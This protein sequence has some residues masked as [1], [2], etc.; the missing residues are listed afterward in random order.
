MAKREQTAAQV[1]RRPSA[2]TPPTRSVGGPPAL[3]A[4]VRTAVLLLVA[5]CVVGVG[6]LLV[7]NG[8]FGVLGVNVQPLPGLP[9]LA[10][11][12]TEAADLALPRRAWTAA[13]VTVMTKPGGSARL[14]TLEPGFP[15]TITAHQ[16][17]GATVWSHITWDGPTSA[18]GGEGW[19][20]DSAFVSY[21]G[22]GRQ[23]GD[24]GALSPQL[25]AATAPYE[26]QFSAALYFPEV[27]QLYRSRGDQSFALGDGF[28]SVL[29]AAVFAWNE[30]QIQ[31]TGAAVTAATAAGVARGDAST[32]SFA[33]GAV[34]DKAGTSA[35]LTKQEI[36]GIQP[37]QGNWQGAQ[38]TPN[39]LLQFYA[40]L[41]TKQ[42]LNDA[43]RATVTALLGHATSPLSA[44]LMTILSPGNG[45]FLV[46]GVSQGASGW[47]VSVCGMLVPA[48]GSRVVLAAVMRDQATQSAAEAG[49]VAF[50]RQLATLL[51]AA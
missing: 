11:T 9:F 31:H 34:G 49:L 46:I 12:A 50:Y 15:V 29:L 13:R 2:I 43:D 36:A 16:K 30:G 47:T 48:H 5:I 10:P 7:V 32:T 18:S 51:A 28:R 38:A 24:V 40:A 35:F 14:A 39:A 25:M 3:G 41:A 20:Q 4:V 44:K 23:I 27:G 37:A 45:G 17:A 22:Q 21:G 6:P 8:V 1:A 19:A 26:S 33:Y 42:I